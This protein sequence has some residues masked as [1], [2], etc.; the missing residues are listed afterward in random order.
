MNPNFEAI[1]LQSIFFL[2]NM[3]SLLIGF[4]TYFIGL[5]LMISS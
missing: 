3:G 1:G 4:I 5:I 2:N